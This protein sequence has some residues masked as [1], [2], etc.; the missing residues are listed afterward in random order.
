MWFLRSCGGFCPGKARSLSRVSSLMQVFRQTLNPTTGRAEWTAMDEDYD[1]NQEVARSSYTDMLH[2]EE[3]NKKYKAGLELAI[4]R[5]RG[6]GQRVHV[7]DIGTGSGLLSMLAVQAGADR[8]TACECF[9][10]MAGAARKIV[11]TNGFSDKITVIPKRSTEITTGPGGD[12][13]ERANILVAELLDTELIGE[14]CLYTYQHALKH[15]VTP[16]CIFVPH[17]ATVYA[18]VVESDF[19]WNWHRLRELPL[20][21]CEKGLV[22]SSDMEACMGAAAV[23]D[24]QLSQV[25][26]EQFKPLSEPIKVFRFEFDKKMECLERGTDLSVV[27]KETGQ[28]QVILM[29]WD[30]EMDP[31]SS[32]LLSVAPFWAHPTPNNMQWRDHWM[33]ALYFNHQSIP[34]EKGQQVALHGRHD[35]YSL[36]FQV[37]KQGSMNSTGSEVSLERP[38][39]RCGGHMVWSRPRLG[40]LNDRCRWG[41]Y[42]AALRQ[43]L[44]PGQTC[45]SVS[46]A[47]WVP[48]MAARLGAQEVFALESSDLGARVTHK[49]IEANNLQD[50]VHI[51]QGSE[52]QLEAALKDKKVAMV[53]A[54]PYY[55]SSLLPWHS[56]YFWY[57]CTRL[58]H[59]LQGGAAVLPARAELVAVAMDFENLWRLRAPVGT[60]EGFDISVMDQMVKDHSNQ[61]DER[62]EPHPLWEYP[63]VGVSNPVTLMNFDL[64]QSVPT[65]NMVATGDI[66]FTRS[67]S[68]NAVALWMNYDLLGDGRHTMS[69]GPHAPYTSGSPQWDPHIRQGVY[70]MDQPVQ[71]LPDSRLVYRVTFSPKDGQ[72]DFQFDIENSQGKN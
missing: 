18:Q 25:K 12:M 60:V 2:D 59:K 54:E 72:M 49:L 56:L 42:A 33:Q 68:C 3:R 39:C 14:G 4:G 67:G 38:V 30:I 1:Y 66:P 70:F 8:V 55:S 16:D 26:Q 52:E 43:V 31:D 61:T 47:S 32:V 22:P 34:V 5:V 10:P 9:K 35:E 65:E 63:G 23:H 44:A 37:Q 36:W 21:G 64:T 6:R 27:I 51:V 62:V 58:R 17:A 45:V 53:I 48:L 41:T 11:K 19:M 28:A 7:L 46:D 69:T 13:S 57:V 29:W 24:I 50:K 40:M 15:L 20:K 71:V